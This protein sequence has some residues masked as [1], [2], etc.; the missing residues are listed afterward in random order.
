MNVTRTEKSL[1]RYQEE[2]GGVEPFSLIPDPILYGGSGIVL[3][4]YSTR[5]TYH[6]N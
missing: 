2:G 4:G 6:Q 3:Y 5:Y 1:N